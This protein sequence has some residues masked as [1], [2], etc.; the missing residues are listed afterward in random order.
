MK[1]TILGSGSKGNSTL[2]QVNDKNILIDVG[3]SFKSI[4]EK[5][6]SVNVYPKD[7][8]DAE[9]YVAAGVYYYIVPNEETLKAIWSYENNECSIVTNENLEM[10]YM[11]LNSIHGRSGK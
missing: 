8:E 1:R 6:E 4:V 3:F 10:L 11:I 9:I 5:L 2:I 7:I